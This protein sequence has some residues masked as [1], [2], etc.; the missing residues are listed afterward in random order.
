MPCSEYEPRLTSEEGCV[1][2]ARLA[3][4]HPLDD[5]VPFGDEII[6]RLY[7]VR[8]GGQDGGRDL[9]EGLDPELEA[10]T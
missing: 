5:V 10:A 4:S 8:E 1:G 3:Q 7:E 6:D 2:E 9:L